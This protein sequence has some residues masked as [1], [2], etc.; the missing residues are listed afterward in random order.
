MPKTDLPILKPQTIDI[1][2]FGVE[3]TLGFRNMKHWCSIVLDGTNRKLICRLR[4]K[5][6]KKAIGLYNKEEGEERIQIE[7]VDDLFDIQVNLWKQPKDMSEV[8]E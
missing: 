5:G 7:S 3:K 4:F 8:N 2:D 1:S 6:A